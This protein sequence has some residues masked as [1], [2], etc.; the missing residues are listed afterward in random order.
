MNVIGQFSKWKALAYV[1][2]NF[3]VTLAIIVIF[4]NAPKGVSLFEYWSSD[5]RFH[6]PLML[7]GP[8][9]VPILCLL[10]ISI[11]WQLILNSGRAVWISAGRL[12]FLNFYGR[13]FFSSLLVSEVDHL[14]LKPPQAFRSDAIVVHVRDGRQIYVPTGLLCETKEVVLSR[15]G[16]AKG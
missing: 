8:I 10:Q 3:I 16:A 12:W 2:F 7:L 13:P 5:E 11:L 14:S 9:V 6:R 15:L 1:G 4:L